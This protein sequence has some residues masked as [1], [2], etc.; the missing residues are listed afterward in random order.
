MCH[1]CAIIELF[2]RL[3]ESAIIL[4]VLTVFTSDAKSHGVE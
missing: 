1:P 3:A 2:V 4:I